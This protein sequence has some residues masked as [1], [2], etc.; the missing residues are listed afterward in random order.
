MS[1]PSGQHFK[2]NELI[3]RLLNEDIDAASAK[4]L[5]DL[6]ADDI[7]AQQLYVR[8]LDLEAAV[9]Q[10]ARLIDDEDFAVLQAQAAL[11]SQ[12]AA[13]VD[14]VGFG[15]V[16]EETSPG[17]VEC[18]HVP[19]RASHLDVSTLGPAGGWPWRHVARIAAAATILI[20]FTMIL[21]NAFSGGRRG[22]DNAAGKPSSQTFIER[23]PAHLSGAVGARW[24]GAHL[25]LAEGH[26]FEKGQRI[27]LI[28]GLA[29]VHFRSGARLIVQGPAIFLIR[30]QSRVEVVLGRIAATVPGTKSRF[31][32]QTA[33][34][35]LI[36]QDTEFGAEIEVDGSMLTEVYKG[37]VDLLV[38]S[39]GQSTSQLQLAAGQGLRIDGSTARLSPLSESNQLHLVRYLPR[40]EMLVNL[41]DVVAGGDGLANGVRTAYYRGI[42]VADGR[43]V[44][45]YAAPVQ[46]DGQ[47][48]RVQGMQFVDGVFIP[49]GR[50]GPMQIDSIGRLY[51][52]FPATAGDCWGGAIM[53]RR[54]K[55][56]N[57]LPSIRLEFHG[58]N[59]GYVNW[60]HIASKP[61]EL[62]PQGHGLIG[63]HSNCGIT[64]DLHAIRSQ[65]PHRKVVRF[66]ALVGN[67]E[68]KP[69][70]YTADA[71]VIVDGELRFQ[72]QGFSREDGPEAIDIP[73]S[74]RD[75]FLVLVVTDKGT[76]TAYDWVAF[77]DPIIEMSNSD[78]MSDAV[79]VPRPSQLR[80]YERN[81]I[82][83][84][85][86]IG[87]DSRITWLPGTLPG[88]YISGSTSDH[89]FALGR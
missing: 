67:L 37:D 33:T 52:E 25:E 53:A 84:A 69:E 4:Q 75:R 85:A 42:S 80:H 41:A 20:A 40:N 28:E 39:D 58:N 14:G 57:S 46:A 17:N 86:E 62:S 31:T 6:L 45:D 27:E 12:P 43:P 79:F 47:Y 23:G 18:G 38:R 10:H 1:Q 21:L 3:G 2:L 8:C 83:G 63:M 15:D 19:R 70:A 44:D 36:S 88:S 87:N 68:S 11:D 56:E 7:E 13:F 72:R 49:D 48:H 54:P 35:D 89:Y 76:N 81:G 74:D 73:L 16:T 34:V 5:N 24:A 29:D 22:L 82:H 61:E 51:S 64:F 26:K 55:E 65:Y 32:V 60:L 59:Y 30:D 77:G 50:R 9:R 71:C 78:A 66:R